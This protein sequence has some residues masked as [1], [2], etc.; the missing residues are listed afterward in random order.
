MRLARCRFA[1]YKGGHSNE[2]DF[3][4]QLGRHMVR[5]VFLVL[6]LS[7]C[8]GDFEFPSTTSDAVATYSDVVS[9]SYEDS[10][11]SAQDLDA[12]LEALVES[13]SDAALTDAKDAWLESRE[14]YLQTEVYRFYDGPIDNGTDG[15]EGLLN[16]WPLDENHIDYV[17]GQDTAGIINDPEQ[18]IDAAALES[19][20]EDGGE[21]NVATGYH[22]IEF[23]LWGQDFSDDGPGARPFTDFMAGETATA[24]NQDRRGLYLTVTGDL[25][26]THL[27][28][29]V[30]SWAVDA[31]YR[32][33]FEADP[34][35]SFENILSGMI[36]LS[37]F[38]TGGERLQA[39][40][41][42][43]SQEDEHSCFSDNTHRDMIQDI[44]GVKNV[45]EGSYTR[46]DGSVVS[47]TGIVDVVAELDS[48]L[49]AR[50]TARIDE[51]LSLANALL[52]PF[53]QEIAPGSA[54]NV[55]VQ[56]L[57][58][59]LA[60]QEELLTEVFVAFELSPNIPTE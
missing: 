32:A 26:V 47:G 36:I 15:P 41:D 51:S 59:S 17:E 33:N 3:H 18:T 46:V 52:P 29:L 4:F 38:E 43:G 40:L 53:D 13:P 45:W 34:E 6:L 9:A 60:A 31:P 39:A 35:G 42:S 24:A 57:V 10:L 19:L 25:L 54:G 12:A 8:N 30:D 37:G 48:D 21:K 44:Q 50:V 1:F 55:R 7:A 14:P 28:Q 58:D 22:A 27:T 2:N 20:N 5:S 11:S 49:A 16:A 23:L 56:A